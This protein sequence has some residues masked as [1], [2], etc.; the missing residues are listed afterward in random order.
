MPA[1][2]PVSGSVTTAPPE[3]S[4]PVP[5]VVGTAMS[6]TIG[7]GYGGSRSRKRTCSWAQTRAAFAVSMTEPPPS[8]TIACGRDSD[9][10]SA[11]ASTTSAVGSPGGLS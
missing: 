10:V 5:A 3:T 8:A 2:R 9:R 11:A 1:L 7:C 6:G 4:E